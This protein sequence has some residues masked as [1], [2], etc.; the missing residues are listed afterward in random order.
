MY[1]ADCVLVRRPGVE[2]RRG[3]AENG[4]PGIGYGCVHGV[5]DSKSLSLSLSLSLPS[6]TCNSLFSSNIQTFLEHIP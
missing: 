5:G 4:L 2:V 3:I 6:A 1:G